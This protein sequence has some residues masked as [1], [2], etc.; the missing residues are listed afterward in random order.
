MNKSLLCKWLWKLE[1]TERTWQTMLSRKYLAN[2]VLSQA[3]MGPGCS[4]FWQS[5]LSVNDIF[6]QFSE[7]IMVNGGKNLF[8]KDK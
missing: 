4:H 1:N 7:K 8:W 6:Q 3:K 5:L 2:Q